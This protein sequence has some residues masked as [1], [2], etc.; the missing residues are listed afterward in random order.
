RASIPHITNY[1]HHEQYHPRVPRDDEQIAHAAP[2]PRCELLD[3][4]PVGNHVNPKSTEDW[5]TPHLAAQ[6]SARCNEVQRRGRRSREHPPLPFPDLV[7]EVLRLVA[8]ELGTR[9]AVREV[10]VAS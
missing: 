8:A 3:V 2:M 1:H 10:S 6:P 5:A 9:A 4:E 7:R